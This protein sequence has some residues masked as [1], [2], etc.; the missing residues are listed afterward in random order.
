VTVD[1]ETSWVSLAPDAVGDVHSDEVGRG[2]KAREGLDDSEFVEVDVD[3]EGLDE[4]V[5]SRFPLFPLVPLPLRGEDE[6]TA[7]LDPIDNLLFKPAFPNGH[8]R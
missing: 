8:N 1:G 6:L 4:R 5:R 3:K 7:G 2:G